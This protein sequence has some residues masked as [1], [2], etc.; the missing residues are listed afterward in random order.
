MKTRQTEEVEGDQDKDQLPS[1]FDEM[2]VTITAL[3]VHVQFPSFTNRCL[4]SASRA[5]VLSKDPPVF[6][7]WSSRREASETESS[8]R[9]IRWPPID[10]VLLPIQSG[11][12][13][14][15]SP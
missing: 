15:K 12:F 8:T 2:N 14:I 6:Y 9:S 11:L 13:P 4:L 1:T 5:L 3:R 10:P 7:G